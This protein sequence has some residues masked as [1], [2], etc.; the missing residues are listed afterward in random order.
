VSRYLTQLNTH[1]EGV[2]HKKNDEILQI[3]ENVG[4]LE[5]Q[6]AVLVEQSQ[7]I[8]SVIPLMTATASTSA[9]PPEQAPTSI[10]QPEEV[11]N[12]DL[13]AGPSVEPQTDVDP[14]PDGPVDVSVHPGDALDPPLEGGEPH[15]MT[16]FDQLIKD[17]V[18]DRFISHF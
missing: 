8:S 3:G 11:L 14:G 4:R 9:P 13:D 7:Q 12:R 1:L 16:C 2:L 15:G 6:L 18:A 10:D 17:R 5:K